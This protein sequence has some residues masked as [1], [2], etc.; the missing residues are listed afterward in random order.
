MEHLWNNHAQTHLYPSLTSVHY[1][2]ASFRTRQRELRLR[3]MHFAFTGRY[4]KYLCGSCDPQ[5]LRR[6]LPQR[7]I[8]SAS[9]ERLP[10]MRLAKCSNSKR[11]VCS[12]RDT[13]CVPASKSNVVRVVVL[14]GFEGRQ[15]GC[16]R[17]SWRANWLAHIGEGSGR[18]LSGIQ[19][20]EVNCP[21]SRRR[22]QG[23]WTVG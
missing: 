14:R 17:K 16:I 10:P 2:S 8:A 15:A 19:H 21:Q 3:R 1:V 13:A 12:Q 11:S 23:A 18:P 22:E 20:R 4:S 7:R 5:L 9:R 6:A